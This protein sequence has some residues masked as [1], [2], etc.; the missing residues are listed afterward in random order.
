[1]MNSDPETLL[2]HLTTLLSEEALCEA[3]DKPLQ[4]AAMNFRL[5][6]RQPNCARD[7]VRIAGCLIRHLSMG[8]DPESAGREGVYIAEAVHLFSMHYRGRGGRGLEAA[9]EDAITGGLIEVLCQLVEILKSQ[10]RAKHERYVLAKSIDPNN[11]AHRMN[12]A[13]VVFE[14][15]SDCLGEGLQ[16]LSPGDRIASWRSWVN[17]HV[18]MMDNSHA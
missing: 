16:Q 8:P 12:L 10:G 13:Q 1:M 11:K 7:V 3:V 4:D 2:A 15:H 17:F 18:T 5:I 14:T 6:T 9:V